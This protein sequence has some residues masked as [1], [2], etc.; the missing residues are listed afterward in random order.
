[1]MQFVPNRIPV[2]G[3]ARMGTP[4]SRGPQPLSWAVGLWR[5][6]SEDDISP[7]RSQWEGE[8]A[9]PRG[10]ANIP[11]HPRAAGEDHSGRDQWACGATRH[12]LHDS[13]A[14]SS[15][16]GVACPGRDRGLTHQLTAH[17]TE[18]R[19]PASKGQ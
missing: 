18:S 11:L 16:R 9:G 15:G 10:A 12:K 3:T 7:A 1:M 17:S 2:L 8:A 13:T 6:T 14:S 4:V 19:N 5:A